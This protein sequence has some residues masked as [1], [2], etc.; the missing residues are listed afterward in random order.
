MSTSIYAGDVARARAIRHK[1]DALFWRQPN[2]HGVGIGII[3]DANGQD[4]DRAGFTIR[5]TEKVDRSTLPVED[6]IPDCLEGVPVQI[7][8]RAKAVEN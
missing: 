1:Y 8:E 4:T 2:V 6:R 5:V 7:L 3:L